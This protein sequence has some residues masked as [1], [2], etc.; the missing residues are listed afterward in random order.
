MSDPSSRCFFCNKKLRALSFD[1]VCQRVF[2]ITHRLPESHQCP[3]IHIKHQDA[4]T[5]LSDSLMQGKLANNHNF[6]DDG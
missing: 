4:K 5:T 2:C 6:Y 3:D 1:C